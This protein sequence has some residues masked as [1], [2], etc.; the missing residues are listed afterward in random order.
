MFNLTDLPCR[1]NKYGNGTNGYKINSN[2]NTNNSN[3]NNNNNH[4]T[5]HESKNIDNGSNINFS[6]S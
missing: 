3:N 6:N 4:N 2:N 1:F 5:D